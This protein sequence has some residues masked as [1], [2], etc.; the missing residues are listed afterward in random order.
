MRAR[1]FAQPLAVLCLVAFATGFAITDATPALAK[2]ADKGLT[3]ASTYTYTVD[4]AASVVHVVAEMS[5]TNTVPNTVEGNYINK[6]YFTGFTVPLPVEAVNVGATQDGQPI[7]V[8]PDFVEGETAFFIEKLDFAKNLFYNKTANVALTYDITGHPP[9]DEAVTRVNAAYASFPAYGI[10]DEGKLTVRVVVPAGYVIDTFGDDAVMTT[11]GDAT[12]YTATDIPQPDQFT[13]FISA[14]A[15]SALAFEDHRVGG[16]SFTVKSWPDDAAWKDFVDQH[17]DTAVPKLEELIGQAWSVPTN[18]VITE[19][20]TAYLYGYAGWYN[21][22]SQ[23][24]EIGENLDPEVL[25][26]ELSHTW[27]NDRWFDAR[28]IDEGLA[29]EYSDL[30]NQALGEPAVSPE[31][32][33]PAAAGAQPLNTWGDNAAAGDQEDYGYNASWFVIDGIV[34]EIGVEKMRAIFDSVANGYIPYRGDDATQEYFVE[35]D[36]RLLL[37]LAENIGGSTVAK[38]L[39]EQY[40]VTSEEAPLLATRDAARTTYAALQAAGGTW[41][42]PTGIR[43]LMSG[44]RFDETAAPIAAATAVL[45]ERD[46]LQATLDDLGVDIDPRIETSY[47]SADAGLADTSEQIAA[48]QNAAAAAIVERD[49]TIERVKAIGVEPTAEFAA[50]YNPD[51]ASIADIEDNL[52]AI[53]DAADRIT[54]TIERDQQPRRFPDLIG[55]YDARAHQL[56]DEAKAALADGDADAASAKAAAAFTIIEREDQLDSAGTAKV[57]GSLGAAIYPII[58]TPVVIVAVVILVIMRRRRGRRRAAGV[59]AAADTL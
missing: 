43:E 11:E 24:L 45:A 33:D 47:E 28:W 40:V 26:H 36:W 57:T 16:A 34:D 52:E 32:I 20:V 56:L 42:P 35:Q 9:R 8:T 38:G 39:I 23:Q 1:G 29:Q 22:G 30:A 4:P 27:F 50:A 44:W 2:P 7:T 3:V 58:A 54:M 13:L 55:T 19:A 37:D 59:A 17:L 41:A 46:A 15:D 21:D 49:A 12:V 6:A 48:A 10:A 18:I 5:F 53:S 25:V 14:R 51:G 31:P